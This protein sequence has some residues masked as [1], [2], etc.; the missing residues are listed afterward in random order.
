LPS[1]TKAVN[2]ENEQEWSM[3]IRPSRGL[4]DLRL[5]E[6]WHYRDLL[7]LL[8]RRDVVTVYKQTLLGAFWFI[9]PPVLN[10]AI[11]FILF[12]VIAKVSTDGINP[13][14]FY[15]SG[16]IAWGYFADC[17]NRTSQTFRANA[18]V[19]GKV[20]FPRL[21]V[22]LSS[23]MS[24]IIKFGVQLVLL[25]IT[26]IFFVIKGDP[27]SPQLAYVWLLPFLLG[28]MMLMG[29]A[30]GILISSLT[31]KYRDLSN[32]VPFGVQLLMYATPVIYPAS[33][34][35]DKYRWIMDI[36]PLT[37]IIESFRFIFLG[38]D[39][40]SWPWLAYTTVFTG[41][42]LLV[43]LVLFNRTEKDFMDTV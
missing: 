35:P 28:L 36:N 26:L 27:A 22:P 39:Q 13:I 42:L 10:T 38:T 14:L 32:M 30:F 25:V 20:Y 7:M 17:I 33:I 12:G 2:K 16:L 43:G 15:L 6:I 19:F 29:L 5:K 24:A 21:I 37:S 40:I 9:L 34:I 31:T 4:F 3:V 8:V 41:I 23:V 18:S 1:A 11:Y